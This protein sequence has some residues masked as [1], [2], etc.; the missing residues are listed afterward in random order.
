LINKSICDVK[1]DDTNLPTMTNVF[2][3][4]V[5]CEELKILV[6]F[7]VICFGIPFLKL[8]NMPFLMKK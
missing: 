8:T 6:P 5:R 1:D 3:Q 4:I 7:E 2:K